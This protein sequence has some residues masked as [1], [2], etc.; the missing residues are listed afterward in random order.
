MGEKEELTKRRI[1]LG[2]AVGLI[3]RVAENRFATKSVRAALESA[4]KQR[5]WKLE[6]EPRLCKGLEIVASFLSLSLFSRNLRLEKISISKGRLKEGKKGR[7]RFTILRR[8]LSHYFA[9]RY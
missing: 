5:N 6:W 9:T 1:R 2:G 8:V 3:A 7:A 4:S